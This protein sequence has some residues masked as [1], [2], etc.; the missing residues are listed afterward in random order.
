MKLTLAIMWTVCLVAGIMQAAAG[1]Q[2][3]WIS[4]FCPLICLTAQRWVDYFEWRN[5]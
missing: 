4:V 3:S 5:K 2:P 1:T